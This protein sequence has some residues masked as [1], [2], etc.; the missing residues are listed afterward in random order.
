MTRVEVFEGV[1][2]LVCL[3]VEGS[4]GHEG[5]VRTLV[6]GRS[7]PHMHGIENCVDN[8]PMPDGKLEDSG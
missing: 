4:Y 8:A 6:S 2:L 1:W 5:V 3:L 7:V